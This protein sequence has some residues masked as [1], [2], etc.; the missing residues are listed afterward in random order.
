M[1]GYVTATYGPKVLGPLAIVVVALYVGLFIHIF[2]VY[3][4]ILALGARTSILSSSK[5]LRSPC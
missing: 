5:E 1:I 2:G 3:G 4:S